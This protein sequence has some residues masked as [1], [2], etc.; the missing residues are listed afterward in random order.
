MP[1]VEIKSGF[2]ALMRLGECRGEDTVIKAEM[3]LVFL[4]AKL[5]GA[6]G[7]HAVHATDTAGMPAQ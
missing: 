3:Q 5:W 6:D 4:E 7:K 1:T 2:V